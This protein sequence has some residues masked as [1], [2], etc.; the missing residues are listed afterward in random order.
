MIFFSNLIG[1]NLVFLVFESLS[2][3]Y[4]VLFAEIYWAVPTLTYLWSSFFYSSSLL[5][6]LLSKLSR[7]FFSC[8][9]YAFSALIFEKG[10]SQNE[11]I[12][13]FATRSESLS[14]YISLFNSCFAY[15]PLTFSS[16]KFGMA[17]HDWWVKIRFR[18]QLSVI[19]RLVSL[20]ITKEKLDV[21]LSSIY[22]VSM[23][24]CSKNGSHFPSS[25]L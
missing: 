6:D 19:F 2:I 12:P 17:I 3:S 16:K 10:F 21:S 20:G 11:T 5:L 9:I 13:C 22:S 18:M 4:K 24:I 25:I 8:S 7:N 23:V 14:S 15:L 1:L